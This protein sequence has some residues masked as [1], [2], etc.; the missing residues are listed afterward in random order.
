M[1]T[2]TLTA[3]ATIATLA[4]GGCMG[5]SARPDVADD[6][7]LLEPDVAVAPAEPAPP[8][9]SDDAIMPRT[10]VGLLSPADGLTGIL[11]CDDY[12]SRYESCHRT[13]NLFDEPTIAQRF[14]ALQDVLTRDASAPGLREDVEGR[15]IALEAQM[16][17]QLAGREC[18]SAL[19]AEPLADK[20]D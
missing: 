5:D 16:Q 20:G 18:E 9:K 15:C 2:R 12:L 4:L 3:L 19:D 1:L 7:I 13:L 14:A 6:G 10:P 11:V 17:T 8:A